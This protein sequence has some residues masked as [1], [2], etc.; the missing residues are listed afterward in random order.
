MAA[1]VAVN[2]SAHTL[3]HRGILALTFASRTSFPARISLRLP[4]STRL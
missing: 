1:K 2:K 3:N 4:Q